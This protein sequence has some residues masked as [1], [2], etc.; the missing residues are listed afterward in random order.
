MGQLPQD[1]ELSPV[2]ADQEVSSS[3]VEYLELRIEILDS[4]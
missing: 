3:D 1:D 4:A 2:G